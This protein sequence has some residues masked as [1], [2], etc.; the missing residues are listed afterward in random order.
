MYFDVQNMTID[1]FPITPVN[2]DLYRF[3]ARMVRHP[4]WAPDLVYLALPA[5]ERLHMKWAISHAWEA[6]DIRQI[7]VSDFI[8]RLINAIKNGIPWDYAEWLSPQ[9]LI[10]DDL[11]H[12]GGRQT[13]Q[14]ELYLLL[15]ER[16]EAGGKTTIVL[17]E[18]PLESLH[19]FN[20]ELVNLLR[21][22]VTE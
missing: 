16:F 6:E 17:S 22:G 13:V 9:V 7:H 5:H 18:Y 20:D 3:C 21:L 2:R 8:A 15:K 10:V 12:L 14:E 19:S 11:Q 1:T 4:R